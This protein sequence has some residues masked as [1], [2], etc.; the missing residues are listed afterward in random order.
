MNATYI[1]KPVSFP[2]VR[3]VSS[4]MLFISLLSHGARTYP[5]PS[6]ICASLK[7]QPAFSIA[8]HCS[9]LKLVTTSQ[10]ESRRCFVRKGFHRRS[11]LCCSAPS[12]FLVGEPCGRACA[13]FRFERRRPR[14]LG[15]PSSLVMFGLS[16]GD[17]ERPPL[18][19]ERPPPAGERPPPAG[20]RPPPAGERPPPRR[21]RVICDSLL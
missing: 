18:A 6:R 14:P 15:S 10:T 21:A 20:E 7:R 3:L 12:A 11:P 17:Y 4:R 9:L 19:G 16:A 1:Q 2:S 5:A 13:C 8:S